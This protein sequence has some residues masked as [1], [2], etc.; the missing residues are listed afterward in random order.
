MQDGLKFVGAER[1]LS[2]K[3]EPWLCSRG[4]VVEVVGLYSDVAG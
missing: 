1:A 3:A 4:V 2:N